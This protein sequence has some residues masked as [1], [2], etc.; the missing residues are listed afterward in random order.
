[1]LTYPDINPIAFSLGP[2]AIRWYGISYLLGFTAAFA[3]CYHRRNRSIP[4]WDA[5]QIVDLLFYAAL[6]VIFGGTFGYVLFYDPSRLM[7]DP[8]SLLKFWEPGRSFHGGALGV[9]VA[10]YIYARISKR[11]FWAVM[12]FIVP[13]VPLGIAAGRIGNFLNAELWGRVTDVPWAMIFPG[14]G[15]TPRHPSQLYEFALEGVLLFVILAWYSRKPRTVGK[16]SGLFAIGYGVFR[17]LA[18]FFREPDLGHGFILGDF[19]TMGQLLSVPLIL[20]GFVLMNLSKLCSCHSKHNEM[21]Q[22]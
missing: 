16:V 4:P 7:Q 3:W 6:G 8:L 1:M 18:E 20:L 12:D 2:L 13:A 10:L 15:P 9:M 21:K 22:G 5:S 11:K 14:A 17:I 19:V